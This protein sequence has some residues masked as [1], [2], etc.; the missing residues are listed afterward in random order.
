MRS[1][2]QAALEQPWLVCLRSQA[3]CLHTKA[4]MQAQAERKRT[5][6]PAA[7]LRAPRLS[8]RPP[9]AQT[10]G[11]GRP[12]F[13]PGRPGSRPH[14]LYK[15]WSVTYDALNEPMA[16][17]SVGPVYTR[18]QASMIEQGP[19]RMAMRT[20][21]V[22]APTICPQSPRSRLTDVDDKKPCQKKFVGARRWLRQGFVGARDMKRR[23]HVFLDIQRALGK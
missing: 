18:H 11:T 16:A 15:M 4:S 3:A 2:P 21:C 17:L 8:G 22:C 5:Q 12:G 13:G 6:A 20:G 1:V 9:G 14:P 10:N 7:P 23:G 19:A